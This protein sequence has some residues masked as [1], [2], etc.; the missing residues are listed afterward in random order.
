MPADLYLFKRAPVGIATGISAGGVGACGERGGAGRESGAAGV[1][2]GGEAGGEAVRAAVLQGG[3]PPGVRCRVGRGTR[4][5]LRGALFPSGRVLGAFPGDLQG[6]PLVL[7]DGEDA[8]AVHKVEV[9]EDGGAEA[10]ED[11]LPLALP[12]RLAEAQEEAVEGGPEGLDATEVEDHGVARGQA[13]EDALLQVAVEAG[14][15]G[16]L[17]VAEVADQVGLGEPDRAGVRAQGL[18]EEVAALAGPGAHGC[19]PPMRGR[20][21][22]FAGAGAVR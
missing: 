11:E 21:G 17:E 15:G 20:C 10:T 22:E 16:G 19:L 8:V 12:D 9:V 13:V 3:F 18:D 5:L 2:G 7:H 6:V 4:L 14:F 1:A